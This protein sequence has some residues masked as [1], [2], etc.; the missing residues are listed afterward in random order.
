M[1]TII[2][3]YKIQIKELQEKLGLKEEE[4]AGMCYLVAYQTAQEQEKG[5]K[6]AKDVCVGLSF[7]WC[8]AGS[9]WK[10]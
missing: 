1:P 6:K 9:L 8:V 10:L 3:K 7:P 5:K 2:K 4:M